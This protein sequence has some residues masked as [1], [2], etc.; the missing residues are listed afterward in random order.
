MYNE[1]NLR[2]CPFCGGRPEMMVISYGDPDYDGC[3]FTDDDEERQQAIEEG[4]DQYKVECHQC[5]ATF[6][7]W[8]T[9][10]T[11]QQAADAWNRRSLRKNEQAR[12]RHGVVRGTTERR[13]H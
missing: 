13:L 2:S 1:Y 3:A 9:F 5:G 10:I 4:R 12:F 11:R 6:A 8:M 7:S